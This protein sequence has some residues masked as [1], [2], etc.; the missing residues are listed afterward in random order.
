MSAH[1]V[2][3]YTTVFDK[4]WSD[5]KKYF[6]NQNGETNW[7]VCCNTTFFC[8]KKTRGCTVRWYDLKKKLEP[9]DFATKIFNI[10]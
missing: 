6:P 9:K 5:K 8:Y 3:C 1:S 7:K 10:N 2:F 4:H